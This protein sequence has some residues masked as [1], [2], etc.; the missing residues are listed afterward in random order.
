MSPVAINVSMGGYSVARRS[1]LPRSLCA[2]PPPGVRPESPL[3]I[4]PAIA[5]VLPFPLRQALNGVYGQMDL[6][7]YDACHA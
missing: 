5:S 2:G 3:R 6:L 4:H 1:F 7:I